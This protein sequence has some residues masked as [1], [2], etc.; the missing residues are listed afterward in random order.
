VLLSP[1]PVTATLRSID[2]VGFLEVHYS[3]ACTEP[4]GSGRV[5][6]RPAVT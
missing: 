1:W 4:A 2:N 5:G 6:L 3:L